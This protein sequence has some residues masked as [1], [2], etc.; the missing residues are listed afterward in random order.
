MKALLILPLL[1]RAAGAADYAGAEACRKCHAAEYEAQSHSAHAHAL[2]P[3]TSSQPG[4]WAFGAGTQAITFVSRVDR[5]NYREHGETW[6]KA[7]DG[8]GVTPGHR[9]TDGIQFR[10]FDPDARILRCFAC[11][12]TGP[13]TLGEDDR[14]VPAE[15]GVRCE[16]CHGPAA[17][18]VRDP[19][20]NRP[21]NPAR[22]SAAE[23]NSFCGQC[24][25]LTLATEEE[26]S[27]VRDPR[28]SRN[29]PMLLASSACF[30]KSRGRLT[31][32]TCHSPH[33][34]L[35]RNRAAYDPTCKNCHPAARHTNATA[36]R[37]CAECHMPAVPQRPLAFTNHR[38]G[39]YAPRDPVVPVSVKARP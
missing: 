23:M 16:V 25:R 3:S 1:I 4:D 10:V 30:L 38:I 21:R 22:M 8:F 31:C 27:D 37:A 28:N 26:T 33:L 6:Y 17:A 20:R 12:S 9:Y 11:H 19:A 39:V 13:L 29:Q 7:L 24:H 5:E 18:H 34:A 14:I 36:G 2:A 15:L 35:E 32:L